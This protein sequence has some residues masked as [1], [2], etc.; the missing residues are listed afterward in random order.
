M[1]EQKTGAEIHATNNERAKIA[2]GIIR[3][4][5]LRQWVVEQVTK[6]AQTQPVDVEKTTEFFYGFI[7]RD[8]I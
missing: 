4:I 2:Q 3:E 8:I 7:T 6:I 5:K 1:S